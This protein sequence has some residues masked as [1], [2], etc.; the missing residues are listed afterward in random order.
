MTK[1]DFSTGT[2]A[3]CFYR[4]I[5]GV[6]D[7][8]EFDYVAFSDQ[9]DLWCNNK[10]SAAIKKMDSRFDGYSSNLIAYDSE[11]SKA[12]IVNKSHPQ[13]KYDYIFQGASA[14][15]T[16]VLSREAFRRVRQVLLCSDFN[17]IK[18]LSHDW[19]IYAIVRSSGMKWINDRSAYIFYRQHERNSYGDKRGF[20]LILKKLRLI[21]SGWYE[22]QIK[23]IINNISDNQEVYDVRTKILEASWP[24]RVINLNLLLKSRRRFK[25]SLIVI[26]ILMVGLI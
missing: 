19:L 2:P 22:S 26:L 21:L 6:K 8:L 4:L 23:L 9:D 18:A 3:G 16:Y 25:E 15:C 13:T 5:L 10:L 24:S 20:N 14:G 11:N 12:W 7:D 17:E 1:F